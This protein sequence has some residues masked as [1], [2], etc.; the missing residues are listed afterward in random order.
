VQLKAFTIKK[1]VDATSPLFLKAATTGQILQTVLVKLQLAGG[2][3]WQ[4]QLGNA[5]V[6]E[7][8]LHGTTE[9]LSFTFQ[10]VQWKFQAG[11]KASAATWTQGG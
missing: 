9:T 2:N 3:S 4:I 7:Y 8:Q 1:Q 6:T 5:L 10:K 11:G